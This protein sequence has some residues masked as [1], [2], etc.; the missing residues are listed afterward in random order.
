MTESRAIFNL[1]GAHDHPI[2]VNLESDAVRR[3]LSCMANMFVY[4]YSFHAWYCYAARVK[5]HPT[6][7]PGN[8]RN[9]FAVLAPQHYV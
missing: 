4:S 7:E 2:R 5:V 3:T 6:T 9:W 8:L 1:E